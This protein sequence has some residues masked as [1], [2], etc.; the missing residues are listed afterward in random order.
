VILNL[1]VWFALH[2]LFTKLVPVRWLGAS[3][4]LPILSSVDLPSLVL[5]IAAAVAIFR[6]KFGMIPVLLA[7]SLAGVVYYLAIGMS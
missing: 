7:S 2:V 5:S 6:F 4:E 3:V 1:A